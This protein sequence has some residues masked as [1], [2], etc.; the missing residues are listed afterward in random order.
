M[1]PPVC[2]GEMFGLFH[3]PDFSL[4]DESY[5][6]EKSSAEHLTIAFLSFL[7]ISIAPCNPNFMNKEI[8]KRDS[9]GHCKI[10][11]SEVYE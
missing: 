2:V 6:N 1:S 7:A 5:A 4:F 10:F 11:F 9:A 3:D 8:F